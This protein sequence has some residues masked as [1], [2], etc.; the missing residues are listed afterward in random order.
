[1]SMEVHIERTPKG[2]VKSV[3]YFLDDQGQECLREKAT[4][5]VIQELNDED[6]IIFETF[7][8]ATSVTRVGLSVLSA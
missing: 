5:V 4:R 7:G 3:I 2:G 8:F 1:M 6:E